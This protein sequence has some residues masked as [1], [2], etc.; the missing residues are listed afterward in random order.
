M[1]WPQT[2]EAE[3]AAAQTPAD[4]IAALDKAIAA[5]R[6]AR[7]DGDQATATAYVTDI[8]SYGLLSATSATALK[9]R[10]LAIIAA[11]QVP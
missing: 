3:L 5:I 10:V 9:A 8:L 7:R 6:E 11:R 2:L 1:P 4:K